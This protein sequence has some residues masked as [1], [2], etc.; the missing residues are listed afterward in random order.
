MHFIK[1]LIHPNHSFNIKQ[2]K[3]DNIFFKSWY[4]KNSRRKLQK[5]ENVT[6]YYYCCTLNM[7]T[8]ATTNIWHICIICGCQ[9]LST[10]KFDHLEKKN[11][12]GRIH[13]LLPLLLPGYM[14][15]FDDIAWCAQHCVQSRQVQ[16]HTHW[17]THF[18]IESFLLYVLLELLLYCAHTKT[19]LPILLLLPLHF[20]KVVNLISPVW[21]TAWTAKK[22]ST[23]RRIFLKFYSARNLHT[24]FWRKF[25][26]FLI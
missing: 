6:Y 5:K 21:P 7:F 24:W 10:F 22:Y 14:L 23:A 20:K 9:A 17:T 26:F 13:G 11:F 15:L 16:R 19:V 25:N 18:H 4:K 1:S 12:N 8:Y 2:F 3:N